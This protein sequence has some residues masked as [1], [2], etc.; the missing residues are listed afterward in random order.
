MTNPNIQ[1]SLPKKK[2]NW[3]LVGIAGAVVVIGGGAYIAWKQFGGKELTTEQAA[4]IIPQDTLMAV[5]ISTDSQDWSKLDKFGTPKA[6]EIITKGLE[7]LKKQALEPEKLNFEQDIQSWMGNIVFAYPA[8]TQT[9]VDNENFLVIC[10]IKNKIKALEFA[11]KLKSQSK[12]EVK[13]SEFKGE[14]IFESKSNSGSTVNYYSILGDNIVFTTE[15]KQLE[16]A[17]ETFKGAP[18]IADKSEVKELFAKGTDIVNPIAQLWITDY[19]KFAKQIAANTPDGSELPPEAL[20]QADKIKAMEVSVGIVD[21]GFHFQSAV[22]I[23]PSLVPTS[24]QQ[25]KNKLIS[26]FSANTILAVNGQGISDNWQ[27]LLEQ[28]KNNAQFQESLAQARNSFQQSMQMDLDKDVIGWMN[29]EF[30]FAIVEAKQ[31]AAASYGMGGSMILETSDRAKAENTLK[32][33]D[34]LIGAQSGG[35]IAKQDKDVGGKKVTEWAIA[36]QNSALLAYSWIDNNSL[37]VSMGTPIDEAIGLGKGAL[38]DSENFKTIVSS[39]PS[40][41]YGYFYVDIDKFMGVA[42]RLG[43]TATIPEDVSAFIASTSSFGGTATLPDKTT[44][45]MDM[46]LNLKPTK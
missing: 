10:G 46:Y 15:R 20:A 33:I 4:E 11:N 36:Q 45:K 32:K 3:A 31:G 25:S 6:R 2:V 38:K 44:S 19:A 14:K 34:D 37:A 16:K 43:F 8:G 28:F 7:S 26:Q 18:S 17:I 41:N 39:L 30:A 13:E 23:D 1:D 24:Y 42:S 29:G 27:Y 9:A 35:F 21:T 40:N 22:K 12:S 5:Y